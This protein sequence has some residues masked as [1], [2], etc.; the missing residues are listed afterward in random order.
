MNSDEITNIYVDQNA[1]QDFRLSWNHTQKLDPTQRLNIKYQFVS[2][3]EAY[4]NNQEINLQNRLK[5]HL[6]SSLNYNKIWKLSSAS[7]GI[8]QFRDLSIENSQP[9]IYS[10]RGTLI[11]NR[12]KPYKYLD[13]PKLNFSLG[14]RKIFGEHIMGY[15]N[16]TSTSND[17]NRRDHDGNVGFHD[18]FDRHRNLL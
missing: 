6:S 1:K 13:G 8:N 4:Q 17:E 16:T 3:K 9:I 18:K 5:Q 12:Y 14:N 10:T 11:N 2:N 15:L 7:I